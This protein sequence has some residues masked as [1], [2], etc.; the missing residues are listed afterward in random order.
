M[1]A[2][3]EGVETEKHKISRKKATHYA[4]TIFK[5]VCRI[6]GKLPIRLIQH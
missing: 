3:S 5:D 2:E 6:S 4:M 1:A